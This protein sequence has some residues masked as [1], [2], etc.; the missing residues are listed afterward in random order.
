MVSTIPDKA[1]LRGL[2][3][4]PSRLAS[5]PPPIVM[6]PTSISVRPISVTTVPVTRGVMIRLASRMHW[7]IVIATDDPA[8]HKPKMI[9]SAV[10]GEAPAARLRPAVEIIGPRNTKLV[11]WMLRRR[12]PMGPI[13]RDWSSVASPET[14]SDML[15]RKTVFARSS[16]RALQMIRG[17]VMIPTNTANTCWRATKSVS[18]KGGLSSRP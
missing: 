18:R 9:P 7:L 6:I 14:N 3:K 8:R 11:P 5:K 4:E 1:R 15:T 10:R 13:P 12:D 17:G 16:L 2:P